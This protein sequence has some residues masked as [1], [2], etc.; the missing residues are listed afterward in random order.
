MEMN[1]DSYKQIDPTVDCPT[2]PTKKF[3]EQINET[4]SARSQ[5]STKEFDQTIIGNI[6]RLSN[7]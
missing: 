7:H 2:K 4:S 3:L 5:Q 1:T 6:N